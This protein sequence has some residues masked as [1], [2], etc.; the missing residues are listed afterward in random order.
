M[1]EVATA[2]A[3]T[4]NDIDFDVLA[5]PAEESDKQVEIKVADKSNDLLSAYMR[6]V[7]RYPLLSAEDTF[8]LAK[9]AREGD[10]RA[11]D[12]LINSN[13][14]LVVKIA[15]EYRSNLKNIMDLIQ[16][17]N[18][19][20]IEGVRRYDPEHAVK[21]V[22]S[23]GVESTK[24]V[25]LSSYAAWWVRAYILRSI[26]NNAR[27]VKVGT[28]QNQRRLFFNL[29]KKREQLRA[30]GIDPTHADLARELNVSEE[31]VAEMDSRMSASER[32]TDVSVG[33]D[34]ES[35]PVTR[36]D[37]IAD[38]KP[39]PDAA[40]FDASERAAIQDAVAKYRSTLKNEK[41]IA[42]IDLRLMADEP[43][44]LQEIGDKFKVSRER[45]RQLEERVLANLRESLAEFA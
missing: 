12:K 10:K 13:L 26:I 5:E 6:S 9:L 23:N 24:N 37:M 4:E 17:G 27:L 45:V 3:N 44:T 30:M 33:T 32:S 31:E 43:L 18:V 15:H 42:I 34:S 28:T 14:R 21:V 40:F 35:T 19:G 7:N 2:T 38:D 29:G 16:E 39:T 20:L 11:A 1:S 8:K 25:K 41:E 22:D 36:G